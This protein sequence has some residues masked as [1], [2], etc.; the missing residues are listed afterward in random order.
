MNMPNKTDEFTPSR[1]DA[2]SARAEEAMHWQVRKDRGLDAVESRALLAWLEA[3]ARNAE[4]FARASQCWTELDRLGRIDAL[5]REAEAL[6]ANR[7]PRRG[8][9][10][11]TSWALGGLAAA[12]AVALAV[13]GLNRSRP[14]PGVEVAS[15]PATY[16]VLESS[17]RRLPL[18]DGSTV[19]LN[20]D[21]RVDVAFTEKERRVTLAAGE[22]HFI[23]AK[24]AA[25][26]FLVS[27]HGVTV[28]AV[29]TAFNVRLGTSRVEVLVTEGTIQ[30]HRGGTATD[31]ASLASDPAAPSLVA[32]QRVV[33][34]TD[35][36]DAALTIEQAG[37]SEIDQA[38]AWQATRLVFDETSLEDVVAA[39][40]RY[41]ERQIV[42]GSSQLRA[43]RF[44][45]A[46]R[47]DNLDGFI[48]LL[49][50][51]S[52]VT[53]HRDT[54]RQIVLFAREP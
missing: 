13:V 21:S 20:G 17:A 5:R 43:L 27:A 22:A 26:P 30:V 14:G 16:R 18:S 9:R 32:G 35:R 38:L 12:A 15:A 54:G 48:R 31:G 24:D 28:R 3:D 34:D 53:A 8:R 29:G 4:E 6:L 25:R 47:A 44:S 52:D 41:N 45:G 7:V 36:I 11:T 42:L 2:G 51:T 33:V 50:A 39:F 23:V 49:Q 46:F 1:A 10:R 37:T 40:N 19:E